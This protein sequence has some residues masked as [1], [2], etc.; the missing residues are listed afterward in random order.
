MK[1]LRWEV[2][3]LA[4]EL[5]HPLSEVARW[6]DG[7]ARA[8]LVIAAWLEALVKA[9]RALPPPSLNQPRSMAQVG[10]IEA[11]QASAPEIK[12]PEPRGIV[13]QLPYPRRQPLAGGLRPGPMAPQSKG[14]SDHGTRPL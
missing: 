5:D 4:E 1:L 3:D 14:A 7:R 13:L 11:V 9:H 12:L 6:F 2:A 8:P 10:P